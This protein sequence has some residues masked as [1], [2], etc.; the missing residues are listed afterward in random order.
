M[1]FRGL[2]R[3]RQPNSHARRR[4]PSRA[5]RPGRAQRRKGV[6]GSPPTT[7]TQLARTPKKAKPSAAA[8]P[9]AAEKGGSVVSPDFDTPQH[10]HVQKKTKCGGQSDRSGEGG[11][12]GLP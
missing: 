8:R 2:R 1:V 9:G 6:W 3:L 4:K 7:A 10:A 11:F 12:G 5:Q